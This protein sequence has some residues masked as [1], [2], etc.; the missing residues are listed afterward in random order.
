VLRHAWDA[1]TAALLLIDAANGSRAALAA[2]KLPPETLRCSIVNVMIAGDAAPGVA[3]AI[4]D[5]TPLAR[6]IGKL[7]LK[8]HFVTFIELFRVYRPVSAES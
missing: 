6:G 3:A 1:A 5:A 7:S 8:P 4:N 2:G